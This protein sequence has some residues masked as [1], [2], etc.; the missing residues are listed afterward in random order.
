MGTRRLVSATLAEMSAAIT[1]QGVTKV[2]VNRTIAVTFLI[3]YWF[4]GSAFAQSEPNPAISQLIRSYEAKPQSV[5]ISEASDPNHS[6]AILNRLSTMGEPAL[7]ALREI[8]Y[9]GAPL[10]T[11]SDEETWCLLNDYA[12]LTTIR[13]MEGKLPPLRIEVNE[14]KRINT[15]IRATTDIPVKIVNQDQGQQPVWHNFGGDYRSGRLARW[16]IQVWDEHGQQVPELERTGQI[17]GGV[18]YS[19][20]LKFG[21]EDNRRLILENYVRIQKPGKYTARVL[22]HNEFLIADITDEKELDNLVL[23]ASNKFE[24]EV[25]PGAKLRISLSEQD[26]RKSKA[27]IS[28]LTPTKTIKLNGSKY[29]PNYHALIPPDSQQGELLQMDQL[30]V[31]AL[32]EELKLP[33]IEYKKR[34]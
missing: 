2:K 4:A 34:R 7:Q 24:I 30:A 10:L 25:A 5:S 8:R 22:Y 15:A 19:G 6:D 32:I 16:R 26:Y 14:G 29:G 12:L 9:E 23:V 27:L 13:R 1:T 3:L 20:E 18:Y 28:R 31:P 33:N 11:E 17:G 21:R